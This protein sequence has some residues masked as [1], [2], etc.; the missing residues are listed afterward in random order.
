MPDGLRDDPTPEEFEEWL[1]AARVLQVLSSIG[2]QTAVTEILRRASVGRTWGA[3]GLSYKRDGKTAQMECAAIP[4][5]WWAGV[6]YIKSELAAFW[7]TG[8]VTFHIRVDRTSYAEERVFEYFGVRFEP[9]SIYEIPGAR[10]PGEEPTALP[11]PVPNRRPPGRRAAPHWVECKAHIEAH[12][13]RGELRASRQKDIETAMA[14]WLE[15]RHL[16]SAEATIRRH[17]KPIWEAQQRG[18]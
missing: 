17:A 13:E 3:G 16:P 1:P 11:P 8:G 14:E 9:T 18:S 12:I 7:R 6:N 15:E 2:R 10:Q 5:D 4:S